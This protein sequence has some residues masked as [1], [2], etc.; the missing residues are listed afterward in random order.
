MPQT[1]LPKTATTAIALAAKNI[2]K[3]YPGMSQPAVAGIDLAIQKGE[4]FGLLGPNGAGKTTT[5][6]IL[7]TLLAPDTGSFSICGIDH[8]RLRMLRRN[9]GLVPQEVALYPEL[10]AQ[11]NLSFFARLYGLSGHLLKEKVGEALSLAGLEEKA[12]EKV[13]TFSGGMKRRLNLAAGIVHQPEVLFL[14]EPTV[15]IDP[16]SRELILSKLIEI[17]ATGTTLLYTT[18]YMEEAQQLCQRIA[19]MDHGRIIAQGTPLG[20]GDAHPEC[21]NLGEVFMKLTGHNLRD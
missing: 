3:Q 11:E 9:I 10:T 7:S 8:S 1:T 6:S 2:V 5:I 14:D 19:V 20:L 21:H 15:G 18:H 13:A 4:I 12:N 16:Q 17:S